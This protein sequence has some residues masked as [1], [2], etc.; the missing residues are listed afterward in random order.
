MDLI[1]NVRK[2]DLFQTDLMYLPKEWAMWMCEERSLRTY[3]HVCSCA[4]SV[5]AF[6]DACI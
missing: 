4:D 3:H 1:E 5:H 2:K 6:R